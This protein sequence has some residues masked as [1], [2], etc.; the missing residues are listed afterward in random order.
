M[1]P[2][3]PVQWRLLTVHISISSKELLSAICG[4][5]G[6]VVDT[7]ATGV[8][9]TVSNGAVKIDKGKLDI[10]AWKKQDEKTCEQKE[11]SILVSGPLMLLDGKACDLSACNRSFVQTKH[12]RSAV[13]LM[14]DGTVFLIAVAGRFEGKA[15]G[16]NIPELTHLLRILGAKKALNLDGGGSTTLWSASAPDNGIVNKLTDNK[17]YDNKGERKVANSLCVY[18]KSGRFKL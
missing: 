1:R 14:K 3:V 8:L 16:I 17:L 9:S 18:D 5:T 13:A 10:I 7:T 15:E 11:G 12:P 2:V 6:V 4:K